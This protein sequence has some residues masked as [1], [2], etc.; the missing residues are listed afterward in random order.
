[1]AHYLVLIEQGPHNYSAYCPDLPGCVSAGDTV[2]GTLA[3]FRVALQLHVAGLREDGAPLP[4]PTLVAAEFFDVASSRPCHA[5][6]ARVLR[7]AAPGSRP[8]GARPPFTGPER[9]G[10]AKSSLG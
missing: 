8:S 3:N 10:R 6:D 4:A 9:G 2:A 5:S 7:L 1:M